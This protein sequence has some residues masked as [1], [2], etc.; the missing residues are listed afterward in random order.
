MPSERMFFQGPAPKIT[1]LGWNP[2]ARNF[3]LPICHGFQCAMAL[4][5]EQADAFRLPVLAFSDRTVVRHPAI[6]TKFPGDT[7][8]FF[9]E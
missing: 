7:L 9:G 1:D 3:G 6:S 5:M 4:L 8:H 2:R